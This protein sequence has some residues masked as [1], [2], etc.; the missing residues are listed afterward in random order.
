MGIVTG[1]GLY[2]SARQMIFGLLQDGSWHGRDELAQEIIN[3]LPPEKLVRLAVRHAGRGLRGKGGRRPSYILDGDPDFRVILCGCRT[4]VTGL[5]ANAIR[6]RL[7]EREVLK[8]KRRR[9]RLVRT[10]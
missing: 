2:R 3:R 10:S 6:S 7:V 5:M 1:D 8:D 4:L 9:Y